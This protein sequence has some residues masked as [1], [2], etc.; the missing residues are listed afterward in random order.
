MTVDSAI[1]EKHLKKTTINANII[2]LVVS[3]ITTLGIVFSFYYETKDRLKEHDETLIV[4]KADIKTLSE[5]VTNMKIYKGASEEQLKSLQANMKD[6][7][8][9]EIRLIDKLD[10]ILKKGK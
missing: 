7:K 4:V 9:V 3:I 1:L 2:S 5:D 8:D 10:E 6:L